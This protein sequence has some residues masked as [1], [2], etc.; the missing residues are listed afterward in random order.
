MKFNINVIAV[1][2]A[3]ATSKA[4]KPYQLVEVSYKNQTSGKVESTKIN[5]YSDLFSKAAG[6]QVGDNYEIT[7]E[8][9][10][11]FWNWT[12]VVQLAPGSPATASTAT[13]NSGTASA[14]RTSTYETPE[15]RAK[16]QV[17]IIKQSSLAQAIASLSVGAKV[18]PSRTT[19]LEEAQAY[20]DWVMG[21]K[22]TS[23]LDMPSD[24]DDIQV[25]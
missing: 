1:D 2:K 14:P 9:V 15:E 25:E 23:V 10:G 11:E 16:K 18:P 6:M 8:K 24:F 4:G 5:Q 19:I 7:K 13:S 3:T 22:K 21:E 20:V 12:A 17:Y